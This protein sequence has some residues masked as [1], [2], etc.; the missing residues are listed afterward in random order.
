ME[1]L[2]QSNL[3]STVPGQKRQVIVS[4]FSV[5][6]KGC[7]CCGTIVLSGSLRGSGNA[8]VA[9]SGEWASLG[10]SPKHSCFSRRDPTGPKCL[11]AAEQFLTVTPF[12][13]SCCWG[14][15][16][17][18]EGRAGA[19]AVLSSSQSLKGSCLC[20]G[21]TCFSLSAE[22]LQFPALVMWFSSECQKWAT[23][24][25]LVFIY[26]HGRDHGGKAKVLRHWVLFNV[27]L[28]WQRLALAALGLVNAGDDVFG[29]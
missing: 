7:T 2:Q 26:Q 19:V 6:R 10:C 15:F 1:E 25:G 9:S 16:W 8:P 17:R 29:L 11:K 4:L 18:G 12:H 5:P 23:W 3:A 14:C 13:G 24:L 20:Y 22:Q 21:R 28:L 27:H